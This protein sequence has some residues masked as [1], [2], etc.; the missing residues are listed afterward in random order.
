MFV[1]LLL[2]AACARPERAEVVYDGTPRHGA[3][4]WNGFEQAWAYNHRINSLGDF[5]GPVDCDR[6]ACTAELVHTA[7]SGSGSDTAAFTSRTTTVYSPDLWFVQGGVRLAI[8][9]AHSEGVRIARTEPIRV[10]LDDAIADLPVAEVVLGGFDLFAT[11]DSDRL[12]ELSLSLSPVT[13]DHGVATFDLEVGLNVDCDSPECDGAFDKLDL[14]VSYELRVSWLLIMADKGAYAMEESLLTNGYAWD[15]RDGKEL[16]PADQ[17][18]IHP[19]RR[20]PGWE[21]SAVTIKALSMVLD[22]DYHMVEWATSLTPRSGDDV[23]FAA[24]FKQWNQATLDGV[25]SFAEPGTADLAATVGLLQ[26]NGAC[27]A[28]HATEGEI[29]WDADGGP[30]GDEGVLPTPLAFDACPAPIRW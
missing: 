8:E 26:T 14:D 23:T 27:V 3:A 4:L 12:S 7:A 10:A 9:E 22:E 29:L 2:L 16:D 6:G 28:V 19:L 24:M 1:L 25:L 13:L 11:G 17:R 18:H 20:Q 30:P 21:R 5:V 15:G